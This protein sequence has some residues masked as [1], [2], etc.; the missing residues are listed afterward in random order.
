MWLPRWRWAPATPLI[1]WLLASVP[2][3]V[4]I[5]SAS[6]QPNNAGDLPA[7]D[8]DSLA[9]GQAKGVSAGWVAEPPV[10]EGQHGLGDGGV[11][12]SGGVVIEVDAVHIRVQ[13]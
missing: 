8:V 9:R 2:P 4:K 6:E 3:L 11:D 7:G 5:R 10:H 12:G 1:A 13:R